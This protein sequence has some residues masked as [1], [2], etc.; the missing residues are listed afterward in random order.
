MWA[1]APDP[2]R[3]A[4]SRSDPHA[5]LPDNAAVTASLPLLDLLLVDAAIVAVA[6]LVLARFVAGPRRAADAERRARADDADGDRR[7][8]DLARQAERERDDMLRQA[9][10]E[11]RQIV[12]SAQRVADHIQAD[13]RRVADEQRDRILASAEA[14]ARRARGEPARPAAT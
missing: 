8:E 3:R 11:A 2:S 6:V 10:D 7:P 5:P 12:Q 4:R 13:A 9:H 1:P 14:D